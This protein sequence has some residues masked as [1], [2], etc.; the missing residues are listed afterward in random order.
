MFSHFESNEIHNV[1]IKEI[2]DN[3]YL[4]NPNV[5]L[6]CKGTIYSRD[7]RSETG[8]QKDTYTINV[9]IYSTSLMSFVLNELLVGDDVMI[10]G[11]TAMSKVK[12]GFS[13]R[14]TVAEQIYKSEWEK[15][16]PNESYQRGI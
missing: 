3:S 7:K 10:V 2:E 14:V 11:H 4:D 6:K 5:T 8:I 13:I 15:Y 9:K 1:K 12:G 16:L